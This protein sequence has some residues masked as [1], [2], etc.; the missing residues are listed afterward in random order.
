MTLID[1]D[2]YKIFLQRDRIQKDISEN[3]LKSIFADI[4][5]FLIGVSNLKCG[6]EKLRNTIKDDDKFKII[7]KKYI[8]KLEYLD[9]FRDHQEHIYEGRLEGKGKSKKPL[10][11]PSML[12]NLTKNL[13]YDFGGDRFSLPEAFSLIESLKKEMIEWN[14]ENKIYPF[15]YIDQIVRVDMPKK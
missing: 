6:L 13:D 8:N 14:L 3:N 5:F 2:F 1:D 11:R 7:Y 12:G 9:I 10:K 4:H 15:W